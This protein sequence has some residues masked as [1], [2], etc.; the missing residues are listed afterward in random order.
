M[1]RET[2]PTLARR[3]G[4]SA[5][6]RNDTGIHG[7][8][9][10]IGTIHRRILYRINNP[11]KLTPRKEIPTRVTYPFVNFPRDI[12][13]PKAAL[14][15]LTLEEANPKKPSTLT[16]IFDLKEELEAGSLD[17]ADK[18]G[19]LIKVV[20]E[21]CTIPDFFF[22][23]PGLPWEIEARVGVRRNPQNPNKKQKILGFNAIIDT[24]VE[25]P[26]EIK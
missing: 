26:T 12:Q 9:N 15:R 7:S 14:F 20:M 1:Y 8:N 5:L 21:D 11:E 6:F 17:H 18:R 19:A 4:N 10:I 22:R 23:C 3:H 16:Q 13:R 24:S 2:W 25:L